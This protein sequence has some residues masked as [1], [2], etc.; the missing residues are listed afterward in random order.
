MSPRPDQFPKRCTK[1]AASISAEAW[2]RLKYD[3]FQPD[4]VEPFE[5]RRHGCGS[6]LGV[7]VSNQEAA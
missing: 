3:G 5:M 7:V 2:R 4:E 1:C 6:T